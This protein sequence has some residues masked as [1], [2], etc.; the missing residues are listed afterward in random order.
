M[1]S[2]P[3]QRQRLSCNNLTFSTVW[4]TELLFC[5]DDVVVKSYKGWFASS[6]GLRAPEKI[7]SYTANERCLLH[8][9]SIRLSSHVS[10]FFPVRQISPHWV[11]ALLSDHLCNQFSRRHI[12]HIKRPKARPPDRTIQALMLHLHN[13][14]G[15]DHCVCECIANYLSYPIGHLTT[16]NTD[17]KWTLL[18]GVTKVKYELCNFVK[19]LNTI[20]HFCLT[21]WF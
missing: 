16:N 10:V 11:P 9:N 18:P 4:H 2:T 15:G 21:Q 13:R 3:P 8:M 6:W 14:H 17:N 20:S 5:L 19:C 1:S 12:Y 7:K